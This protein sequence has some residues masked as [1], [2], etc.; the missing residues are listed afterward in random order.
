MEYLLELFMKNAAEFEAASRGDKSVSR[1]QYFS[2]INEI[3]ESMTA[4]V[5]MYDVKKS[6]APGIGGINHGR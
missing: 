1:E 4:V 5:T 2:I 3:W 6:G